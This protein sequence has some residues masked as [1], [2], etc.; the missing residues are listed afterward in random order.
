[1]KFSIASDLHLEFG[2]IILNNDD[3]ADLLI[4]AGDICH[5][6]NVHYNFFEHISSQFKHIIYVPGNHEYYEGDLVWSLKHLRKQL[7]KFE[8]IHILENQTF[9]M[10]GI[11]FIGCTLWTDLNRRNPITI[12]TVSSLMNDFK[13]IKVNHTQF[14]PS[15]WYT[16]YEYSLK[17]LTQEIKKNDKSVVITHYAPSKLSIHE[18]H[19]DLDLNHAYFTELLHTIFYD[20]N[21]IKYWIHG[22]T[23][24]PMDYAVNN[25]RVVTNPRGY[26]GYEKI[27]SDYKLK[28]YEI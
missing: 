28:T 24:D 11:K 8:N 7:S 22:H 17:F 1:M 25:I 23:H 10:N 16:M 9:E 21:N 12:Q 26:H 18:R 2:D 15:F 19:K 4:L 27:S 5:I 13:F 6:S 3:E 14:T 20:C